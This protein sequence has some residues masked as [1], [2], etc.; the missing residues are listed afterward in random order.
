MEVLLHIA[1]GRR[2][3]LVSMNKRRA[4]REINNEDGELK[5]EAAKSVRVRA[6]VFNLLNS[7][8]A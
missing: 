6:R 7:E 5:S 8:A 4:G 1:A 3:T 2:C